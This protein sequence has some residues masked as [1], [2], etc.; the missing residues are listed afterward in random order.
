VSQPHD[1]TLSVAQ[2]GG[3]GG[4]RHAGPVACVTPARGAHPAAAPRVAEALKAA[5]APKASRS[6]APASSPA[7]SSQAIKPVADGEFKDA[8]LAETRRAKK[9]FYGTVVAQARIEFEPG[10]IVFAFTPQHRALRS[11]FEQMRGWLE[12]TATQLAGRH[13][14][15][16]SVES[17]TPAAPAGDTAAAGNSAPAA[18]EKRD[19]LKEKALAEPN[20]QAMLDVFAAEITDVEER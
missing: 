19:A 12:S 2:G 5:S 15:V 17:S 9:F 10:R 16:V 14:A 18:D 6:S 1:Q 4:A 13:I 11:Q 20:V 7:E 3:P 8:F